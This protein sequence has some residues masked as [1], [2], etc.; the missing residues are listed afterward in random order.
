MAPCDYFCDH[1]DS[2]ILCVLGWCESSG[3]YATSRH[4]ATNSSTSWSAT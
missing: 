1:C 4:D 2:C 3:W